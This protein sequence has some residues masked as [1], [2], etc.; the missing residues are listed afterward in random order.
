MSKRLAAEYADAMEE[1]LAVE[2]LVGRGS[3]APADAAATETRTDGGEDRRGAARPDGGQQNC[4]TRDVVSVCERS[5]PRVQAIAKK[6]LSMWGP[7]RVLVNA[8]GRLMISSTRRRN[9]LSATIVEKLVFIHWNMQLISASKR[10]E[11]RYI[12]VWADMVEDPPEEVDDGD[13]LPVNADEEWEAAARANRHKDGCDHVTSASRHAGGHYEPGPWVDAAWMLC[14]M[15]EHM[16]Q[17]RD[18]GKTLDED[19]H[20]VFD[21]WEGLDPHEDFDAYVGDSFRTVRYLRERVGGQT[22]V[23]GLLAREDAERDRDCSYD[24]VHGSTPLRE[25]RATGSTQASSSRTHDGA[26]SSHQGAKVIGNTTIV[27]AHAC[28]GTA[29]GRAADHSVELRVR[30]AVTPTVEQRAEQRLGERVEALVEQRIEQRAHM[31]RDCRV[32]QRAEQRLDVRVDVSVDQRL[33]HERVAEGVGKGREQ[34]QQSWALSALREQRQQS[35]ALSALADVDMETP[36]VAKRLP[37][38]RGIVN[39]VCTR[40]RADDGERRKVSSRVVEDD[41]DENDD[42]N[43]SDEMSGSDYAEEAR[44]RGGDFG[45]D[46]DGSHDTKDDAE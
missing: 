7:Q 5:H 4:P 31:S 16:Q 22:D 26:E 30:D 29:P 23:D 3:V 13:V 19:Q 9:N 39:S 2:D 6:V 8:I 43:T 36:D 15:A 12:D 33:D 42:G 24:D 21:D 18:K 25:A 1:E 34:R 20:D 35:W 17:E 14:E 38:G 46:G 27:E 41:P 11:S 37:A 40:S 44:L 32:E 10:P 45:G 28:A